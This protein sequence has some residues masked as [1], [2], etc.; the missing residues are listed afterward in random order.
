MPYL[1]HLR[2]LG[3]ALALLQSVTASSKG[4][5]LSG[6]VAPSQHPLKDVRTAFLN[7]SQHNWGYPIGIAY[8]KQ[9]D[10]AFVSLSR[11]VS[12]DS[13]TFLVLDTSSFTPTVIRDVPYPNTEA[14]PE[15]AIGMSV[16]S[17]GKFA[18]A[19]A[20]HGAFVI[21]AKLAPQKG[22]DPI[23]GFLSSKNKKKK[24]GDSAFGEIISKNDDYLFVFQEY[25]PHDFGTGDVD[26]FKLDPSTGAGTAIGFVLLGGAVTDGVLSADGKKLYA[27]SELSASASGS[28]NSI[29]P[30]SVSVLDVAKLEQ[31]P[32]KALIKNIDTGCSAV[33]T[34]LSHDGAT[35]WVTNRAS[36]SVWA[37]DTENIISN[38]GS[39]HIATVDVGTAPV[40][41][42][43]VNDD[44]RLLVA[45]SNR[46]HDIY[47]GAYKPSAT[48]GI[49]VIDVEAALKNESTA[50]LGQIPSGYFPRNFALS[51]D[52][53]TVLV[54]NT[55]SQQIMAIDLSTIP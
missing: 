37:F 23:V 5:P 45:N 14:G 22:S 19:A 27:I 26:A 9:S 53:K 33:R 49:S 18:Y 6:P 15:G 44:T 4:C 17:N 40:G 36:N 16:S 21:H 29:P 8:A 50:N 31:N 48:A 54:S 41:L 39:A 11:N 20:G 3:A 47:S 35:L 2:W 38:P 32:N 12:S 43:L 42:I 30:G 25:G 55:N 10:V 52:K 28:S 34:V 13:T 1:T 46:F 51:L 7:L 24:A